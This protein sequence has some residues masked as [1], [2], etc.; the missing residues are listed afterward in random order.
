MVMPRSP[1]ARRQITHV[2]VGTFALLLRVLTWWEAAGLAIL[3]VLFNLFVLPR[4]NREVFRPGDLESPGRSGIVIYPLSVLGLI[5]CF[6]HRLD[7]AAAA[8]G[9]LAAG[10]GMATLV[11]AHVRTRPLPWN[12]AKS[13]GGLLAFLTTGT[14]A[15]VGLAVWTAA[16]VPGVPVWWMIA[17]PA[18]ATLA[19][20][21]VETM[22]L[23][24]NDNIS[25]PAIAALV[26]WTLSLADADAFRAASGPVLARLGPALALNA[27]VALAGWR[28]RT[29]T[30]AGA[31]T[32]AVIGVLVFAGAGWQG[33][34]ILLASFVAAAVTTRAGFRRKALVGIAERRGGARGPGNAVANTGVGAWAALVS[35]GV[36]PPGP[37]HL[38]MV[39]AL[40]TAASDT[41][42]SEIGKAWG[43]TTW[44]VTGWR[45]VPPGTSGA[46]SLEGTAAGVAASAL[47]GGLAVWLGLLPPAAIV[48]VVVAAAV[49]SIVESVLGA[50]FEGPGILDND[51]LN[52]INSLVGAGLALALWTLR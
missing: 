47:L 37:A 35:L 42:A 20:G 11:G 51:A 14:V 41:V 48:V 7:I 28:A 39:A 23:R 8:W 3:A 31:F 19:A 9:I 36:A 12:R 18:A 34:V 38:A 50:R 1:E 13:A 46:V 27:A 22:P 43:R 6:P 5:L 24:L 17:A 15:S 45:K 10:D 4:I 52:F 33:W 32:G 16:S 44:L 2:L 26:L 29:V 40:V 21:L 49:A 25:V 30:A